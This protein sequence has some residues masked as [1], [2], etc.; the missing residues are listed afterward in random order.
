MAMNSTIHRLKLI[1]KTPENGLAIFCGLVTQSNNEKDNMKKMTVVVEPTIPLKRGLYYCDSRFHVED[2]LDQLDEHENANTFG[3]V[4]VNGNGALF[5]TLKGTRHKVLYEKTIILPKK[6]GKGGQSRE[7]FARNR[8][9]AI[10]QYLKTVSEKCDDLFLSKNRENLLV[11]G[12]VIAGSANLKNVLHSEAPKLMDYRLSSKILQV[13]DTQYGG[14][15]G[16]IEAIEK[17]KPLMSNLRYTQEQELIN[18]F[19]ELIIQDSLRYAFGLE[20]T[21]Y[22]LENGYVEKL[23]V[24]DE[25]NVHRCVIKENPLLEETVVKYLTPEKMLHLSSNVQVVEHTLLLK[26]LLEDD[27][28]Q[29]KYGCSIELVSDATS[30]SQQFIQGFGGIA[31]VLRYDVN[32]PELMEQNTASDQNG[33]GNDY[34]G[35]DSD[36]D[37]SA[38]L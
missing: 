29:T 28:V 10:E 20:D 25:Y 8:E 3:F 26:Y 33:N 4:I 7:R 6:H 16:F 1:K 34:D 2:L 18:E 36:D 37:L 14:Y 35:F 27:F 32:I 19:M 23:L 22:A 30:E 15:Q 12:L 38:F 21:I 13:F 24:H 11:N 9:I 31:A 5:G 17:A